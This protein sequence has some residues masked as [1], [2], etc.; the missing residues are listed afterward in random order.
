MDLDV[1]ARWS[2]LLVEATPL[3]LLDTN[4]V[5][6]LHRGDRRVSGLAAR[7]ARLYASPATILE[8]QFLIEAGRLRLRAGAS[9][10]LLV[11]DDRWVID[12]PASA[13]WFEKA[14]EVGFTR[15]PF[16]RLIVAHARLRRWRLATGDRAL[17]GQLKAA[18]RIEL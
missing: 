18:E 5:I 6:W 12:D 4:A 17:L 2:D 15:D 10:N 11:H 14:S 7:A 3:I 8:L 16:D 13:A 1:E 9:V